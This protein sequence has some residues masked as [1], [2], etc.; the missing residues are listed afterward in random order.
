MTTADLPV[1]IIGG[2]FSGSMLAARLAEK[3]KASVVI[4]KGP[5]R[6][7][8]VAYA[9]TEPAHRLNV[10]T[11]NMGAL[12]D[13]PAHFAKWLAVHHPEQADPEGF[14]PRCLY[15]AYVQ[16]RLAQVQAQHQGLTRWINAKA[17][18]IDGATVTLDDGQVLEGAAIVLASGNPPPR[19]PAPHDSPRRISDPWADGALEQ[20]GVHDDI[21]ILGTGLTMVDVLLSLSA[22]GWRGKAVALS[23]RG[24]APRAHIYGRHAPA[25][26]PPESLSGPLSRRLRAV[27][28]LARTVDWRDIMDA[29]RSR[30]AALW[31]EASEEE[32]GRFLRHLRPWWDVHRHRIAP[33]IA[34][35]LDA[36]VAADRLRLKAGRILSVKDQDTQLS[37]TY[38]PRGQSGLYSH[39]AHWMIDCTGPGHDPARDPLTA[40]LVVTGRLSVDSLGLGLRVSHTGQALSDN[41]QTD[42][43]I[44]VLGPPARGAFWE[45]IAVPDLRVRI[46][47]LAD[48][49]SQ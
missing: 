6:A 41:G 25:T 46:E 43:F 44:H 13:D 30:T 5:R 39:H 36:L 7:L 37:I 47:D 12:A 18:K 28:R 35:E 29:F 49:L 2:G 1:L 32:R 19:Q 31:L 40:P 22:A 11:G 15:G 14:A 24:L 34:A 26:L 38:Q 8:G 9:T 10:R 17:V 21:L 3:G 27:R 33:E 4:E 48:R 45:T 20:V 42:P 23:R 16:D